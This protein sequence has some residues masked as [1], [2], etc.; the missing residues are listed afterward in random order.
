[1]EVYLGE[2]GLLAHVEQPIIYMECSTIDVQTAKA[3][4][5]AIAQKG[6]VCV[7]APVSG[8]TAS[9]V[10]GTLTFMVGGSE[11]AFL[12]TKPILEG[13]GK[14]IFHAGDAGCGQMAKI[15]NNMLLG[16]SMIGVCEAFNLGKALG[17]SPQA[18]F[19][20][21][22]EASGQCWS[23]T[24]YCPVPGILPHTPANRDYEPGFMAKMMLKDLNLAEDAADSVAA[25]IPMG[26]KARDLYQ[27][28]CDAGGQDKD[29]SGIIEWLERQ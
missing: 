26:D 28:F 11:A 14:K 6:G 21:C 2:E 27:A 5:E 16:I 10:A 3:I 22:K 9:A 12:A 8:G 1:R 7:D 19:D 18:F 17:L 25:A 15:C 20:I 13:M 23:L 24:Q 4:H 29:F